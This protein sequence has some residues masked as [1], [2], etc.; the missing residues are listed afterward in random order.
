M[1]SKF[2]VLL[3]VIFAI[4]IIFAVANTYYTQK[5][6]NN[7][8]KNDQI[9]DKSHILTTELDSLK[10]RFY[11]AE[12]NQRNFLLTGD[13]SY[14]DQVIG[15]TLPQIKGHIQKLKD[16]LKDDAS[17]LAEINKIDKK[18][19]ERVD[20]MSKIKDLKLEQGLVGVQ[21]I[22]T[23]GEN[24]AKLN[25][26]RS[27]IILLQ[28]KQNK[29]MEQRRN[30]TQNQFRNLSTMLLISNVSNIILIVL[31]NFFLSRELYSR[32][33]EERLKDE[34]IN[35]A[36]HELKTPVTSLKIFTHVLDKKLTSGNID[37][38]KR[39]ITKL[40]MQI[41][42]LTLLIS[43]LLDLSR[44]QTGKM[45]FEKVGF[46]LDALIDETVEE[47]QGTTKDHKLKVEG[48][49]NRM[50]TADR[51]RIY[52]VLVNLLTNAIKYSPKGGE[53][54]VSTEVKDGKAIVSVRDSGIGIDEKFQKK[55]F[56]RLYQV[57]DS[58]EKT[59]PGLGVGLY[60][61][62]QI[63]NEHKGNIWVESEK[64]KGSTFHFSLPL[65]E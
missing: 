55:I 2:G 56:E 35:M 49:I 1:K 20:Q 61:S 64:N 23:R 17:D 14:F 12:I 4:A 6:L 31:I 37:E 16:L 47:I 58:A 11:D 63:I 54:L 62:S 50:I 44:I 18:I 5:T 45:R 24:I 39:Y 15:K 19:D 57:T 13:L 9:F 41:N 21:D 43:D 26:I 51:Y 38:A 52:Q 42:K 28:A 48:S 40:N 22:Y 46:N 30:T 7:L 53:I 34:F 27:L 8:H 60:V 32:N 29:L 3:P 36:S 65:G 33:K 10:I 59:Y 25:E